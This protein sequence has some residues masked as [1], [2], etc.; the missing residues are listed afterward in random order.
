MGKYK[1]G[2]ENTPIFKKMERE[3]AKRAQKGKTG[4]KRVKPKEKTYGEAA[5]DW[6]LDKF[7]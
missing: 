5:K 4:A 2:F 1:T 7:K 6:L 3:K